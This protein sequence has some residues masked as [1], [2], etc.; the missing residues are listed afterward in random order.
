[1]SN[2]CLQN[3][4]PIGQNLW[5]GKTR[6]GGVKYFKDIPEYRLYLSKLSDADILCPDVSVPIVSRSERVDVTPFTGFMEF[7]SKNPTDQANYSA[8]SPFWKGVNETIRALERG[9]YKNDL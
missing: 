2:N 8:M 9:I 6:T 3:L 4:Y 7:K 5:V 1:M